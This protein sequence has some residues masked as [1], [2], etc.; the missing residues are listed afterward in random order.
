MIKLLQKTPQDLRILLGPFRGA[1]MFLNP[2]N[3]RRKLLGL[4]EYVLNDWIRTTTP[5]KD[6]AFDVGANTGYDLYGFAH[7]ISHGNTRVANLLAFEPEAASFP[8]L[9]A[10]M[11]WRCYSK[12]HVEIIEKFAGATDS[13]TS[14]TLDRSF[15]ERPAFAGLRGLIKI[16]VEGAEV[17]VLNGATALLDNPSHD[18]LIE[19]HGK[20]LIPE[21][22]R[23]FVDRGRPI[24]VRSMTPLPIIGAEQRAIETYWLTTIPLD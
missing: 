3:S 16:D 1:R 4:Y 2:S 17:D 15:S 24:L 14:V 8:E 19:I 18:W 23:F 13:G 7:L 10:P 22:C 20:E 11:T 9:T 6:F 12:C 5:R 21:V